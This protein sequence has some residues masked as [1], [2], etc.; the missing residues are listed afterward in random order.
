MSTLKAGRHRRSECDPDHF[1]FYVCLLQ[2]LEELI[3]FI[4]HKTMYSECEYEI[5]TRRI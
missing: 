5:L 4:L 2:Y 3:G 1:I